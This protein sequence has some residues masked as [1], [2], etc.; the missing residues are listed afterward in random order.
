MVDALPEPVEKPPIPTG[1]SVSG[2]PLT[3]RPP[4]PTES[5]VPKEETASVVAGGSVAAG[6]AA[7]ADVGFIE[8]EEKEQICLAGKVLVSFT[9][10]PAANKVNLKI[11][12]TQD[13]PS[14]ERGG[15]ENIQI[16]LCVLPQRK[17]RYRTKMQSST[18]GVFN[19]VFQFEHMTKDLLEKCAIRI[20]VYGVQRFS[21]KLMGEVK[22]PLSKI[23]LT[24]PLADGD[25]WMNLAP[26]GLVVSFLFFIIYFLLSYLFFQGI[27]YGVSF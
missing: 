17:Q 24:S 2:T 9:Y 11:I 26:K 4:P 27:F 16:H 19:Q 25:I 3:S 1:A 13:L 18:Q 7:N 5:H 12:R 14:V 8:V 21:R 6:S 22:V 15:S 10:M 20:R 23:D